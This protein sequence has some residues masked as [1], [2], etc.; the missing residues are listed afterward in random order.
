M[1]VDGLD[2]DNFAAWTTSQLRAE[3][4]PSAAAAA[5]GGGGAARGGAAPREDLQRSG[6]RG[7]GGELTAGALNEVVTL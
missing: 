5:G 3:V 6:S 2:F 7:V 4:G 1:G